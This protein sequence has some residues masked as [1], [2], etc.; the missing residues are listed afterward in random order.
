MAPRK[1]PKTITAE[2]AKA[3][4]E[5][6]NLRTPT[7]VRNRAMMELMYRSG[8]RASEVCGI[9]LRDWRRAD[10]QI[11][12]RHDVA[13]GGR[14]AFAYVDP[15]SD[16]YLDRWVQVRR[17]YAAGKPHLFTTLTG[18]PLTRRYLWHML[19]RY[20][21]RAGIGHVSP[22]MLRHSYATELLRSGKFNLREVQQL[23]RHADI[24]TT[25]I[26]TH[27]FDEDLHRKIRKTA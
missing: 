22:H 21:R 17:E 18:N 4:L 16:D 9:G 23:L 2:E 25:T 1:L 5:V 7:G 6:A 13:K 14:E 3:L 20:S 12:L 19:D 26:Y 27:V 8:L 10:G 24:R 15:N 11:H